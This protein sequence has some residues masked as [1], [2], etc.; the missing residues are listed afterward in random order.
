MPPIHRP[1]LLL[2][3]AKCQ[4]NIRLLTDKARSH[5]LMPRPHFKAHQSAA[6]GRWFEQA[7]V[8]RIAVSSVEMAAY[9]AEAGWRNILIAAPFNLLEIDQLNQLAQRAEVGVFVAM[10]DSARYLAQYLA[11]PVRAWLEVDTGHFKAGIDA[12][13]YAAIDQLLGIIDHSDKLL[14]S[15]FYAH[16]GQ[17]HRRKNPHLIDL[18]LAE[19]RQALGQLRARYERQYPYLKIC[20]GDTPTAS[21]SDDFTGIDEISAGSWVFYDLVQYFIGSCQLEQ[22]ALALACPVVAKNKARKELV[23]YGGAAH[24]SS[25]FIEFS[26][27]PFY[28]YVVRLTSEGWEPVVDTYLHSLSHQHGTIKASDAFFGQVQVG[29]VVGILPVH[30]SQTAHQMGQYLTLDGNWLGTMR[31]S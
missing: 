31:H 4:R 3:Q 22:V 14:F 25:E 20:L 24:L 13:D 9:F 17:I 28:G 5:G 19:S 12:K 30:A 7:G 18:A 10:P 21:I 15:G 23:I 6:V 16:A 26:E 8:D 29:E 11:H 1:T 27:L 2:D